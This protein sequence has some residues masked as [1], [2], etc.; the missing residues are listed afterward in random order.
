MSATGGTPERPELVRGLRAMAIVRWALLAVVVAVAAAT[1]WRF[2]LRDEHAHEGPARYYCPMHPQIRSESPGTCP[3]CFMSLEP[4]PDE[5][6]RG[7]DHGVADGD[8]GVRADALDALAPVMLTLERRQAIGLATARAVRREVARELRLPAVIEARDG[9]VSEVRVRAEGFVERVAPAEIGTRVRAG[10]T[11]VWV[12]APEI[13][14]AQE[15][16]LAALRLAG[17]GG[18]AGATPSSSS[19]GPR[20]ADAARE[21]L[22][23]LGLAASDVDRI[24]AAGAVERLVSARA[25]AGG[26]I[27]GRDVALGARVAPERTLFEVTDLSRVWATAVVPAG[28]LADVPV[29]TRG[30]FVPRAGGAELDVE[31]VLVAP[32]VASDTRTASVRFAARNPSGALVPGDIGEVLVALPAAER[33]LVPRDAIVDVGHA[34]YVFVER[35]PGLFAPRP[36]RAGA[37]HGDQREVL[38][39]VGEGEVVVARGA[40]LL[41]SESRLESALR[42]AEGSASP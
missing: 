37:L 25:P 23:S 5:R 33:V 6:G 21:R 32:R 39:G 28:E 18:A 17:S 29:G 41:D 38:E 15:E 9:A 12:Y 19:L 14:R 22:L 16:M 27:T 35:E 11:L 40:F 31:A 30:R 8:A 20:V 36:V 3:I 42:P 2:V 1:W 10:Q 34:R 13:V 4:I 26:V 7:H 24:A